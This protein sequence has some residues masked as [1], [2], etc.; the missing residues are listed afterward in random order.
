[1]PTGDPPARAINNAAERTHWRH[2][3]SSK[4]TSLRRLEPKAVGESARAASRTARRSLH[5]PSATRVTT[6]CSAAADTGA[7]SGVMALLC[8]VGPDPARPCHHRD[9]PQL[10]SVAASH[11]CGPGQ[12]SRRSMVAADIATS[13]TAVSSSMS[14]SP[15]PRST[16]TSSPR[17]GAS[18]LPAGAFTTA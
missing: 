1:M 7:G 11:Q 5:R 10:L 6:T 9:V 16:G 14:N 12:A 2:R 15:W 17:I 4:L 3:S 18:R 13:R 8:R